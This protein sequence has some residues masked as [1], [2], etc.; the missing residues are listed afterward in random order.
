VR[1]C[2]YDEFF[3]A[4]LARKDADRYLRKGLRTSARHVLE[5]AREGGLAGAEVLEIGGGVGALS[6]ELVAAGAAHATVVELSS[7]YEEAARGLLAE[8][9]LE[10]RVEHRRGD[11]VEAGDELGDADVVVLERVVCC[12]PDATALVGAVAART[13]RRL[14]LSYPRPGAPAR[15]FARVANLVLRLRRSDFR[16]AAHPRET[17]RAA[18]LAHGLQPAGP[19][20]GGPVWRVAAFDR[21]YPT[22]R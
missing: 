19:E 9:G 13:R 1:C 20:S 2:G 18:A 15:A 16:I 10:R 14:V 8:R 21:A 17:I 6:V 7:G 3:D 12:Y 11:V 5:L 4:R 22:S